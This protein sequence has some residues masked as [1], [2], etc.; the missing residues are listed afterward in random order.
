MATIPAPSNAQLAGSG[1]A[2]PLGA[3]AV[4]RNTVSCPPEA[5]VAANPAPIRVTDPRTALA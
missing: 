5:L 1:V 2:E 4:V 3:A